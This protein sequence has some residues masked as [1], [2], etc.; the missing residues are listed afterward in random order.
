MLSSRSIRQAVLDAKVKAATNRVIRSAASETPQV[1]EKIFYGDVGVNPENLTIWYI[2]AT[3]RDLT[4]AVT[5]GLTDKVE[6]MTLMQLEAEYYPLDA[7]SDIRISFTSKEDIH[8]QAN[9]S[10]FQYFQAS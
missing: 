5:N 10:Y 8:R 6:R 3:D 7:L 9:G 1:K 2:F 4:E